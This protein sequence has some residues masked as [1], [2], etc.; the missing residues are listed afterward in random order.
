MN[1]TPISQPAAHDATAALHASRHATRNRITDAVANTLTR[2]EV[3]KLTAEEMVVLVGDPRCGVS[4]DN[5]MKRILPA[6]H[7]DTTAMN[8]SMEFLVDR[9]PQLVDRQTGNW[10]LRINVVPPANE[11]GDAE[12]LAA[13]MR[14]TRIAYERGILLNQVDIADLKHKD[15]LPIFNRLSS[16]QMAA[17]CEV[18]PSFTPQLA[19][20]TA[21]PER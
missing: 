16:S 13:F 2:E 17:T 21:Q 14:A 20:L 8:R 3:L 19:T 5:I 12:L 15:L 9:M 7:A 6:N 18:S 1:D 11:I 4:A 10:D